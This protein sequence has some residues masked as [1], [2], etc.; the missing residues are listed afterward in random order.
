[1]SLGLLV[2]IR[3]ARF[4]NFCNFSKFVLP[5]FPKTGQHSLK[6]GSVGLIYIFIIWTRIINNFCFYLEGVFKR[7]FSTGVFPRGS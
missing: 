7:A 2:A 1:M 4:C 3:A 5:A 6:N